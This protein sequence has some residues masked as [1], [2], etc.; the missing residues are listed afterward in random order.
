MS[1]DHDFIAKKGKVIKGLNV[2]ILELRCFILG[3]GQYFFHLCLQEVCVDSLL[4]A[5]KEKG[6]IFGL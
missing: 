2:R 1:L 5:L 4:A 6:K 3:E